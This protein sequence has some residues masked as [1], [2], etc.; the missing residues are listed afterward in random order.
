MIWQTM[1]I[2]SSVGL[3]NE[4]VDS[5]PFFGYRRKYLGINKR[6]LLARETSV[7]SAGS[8]PIP[9]KEKGSIEK[10][11]KK[12]KRKGRKSMRPVGVELGHT[13]AWVLSEH[14]RRGNGLLSIT[15]VKRNHEVEKES[16]DCT[17]RASI[18]SVQGIEECRE[19]CLCR[20]LSANWS[21]AAPFYC[22]CSVPHVSKA[23]V[24]QFR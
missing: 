5:S 7:L 10:K 4:Y 1:L 2:E 19:G 8:G 13:L 11:G 24:G 18:G 14:T 20:P 22:G 15:C 9:M 17:D 6:K 23:C 3:S 21:P 16:L 12:I